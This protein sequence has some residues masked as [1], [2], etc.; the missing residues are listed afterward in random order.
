MSD[1]RSDFKYAF[2][3][4]VRQPTFTLIALLTL[5]LGIGANTAIFSVIKAVLLNPLPYPAPEQI[6]VLWEVSPERTVDQVSVPTF[7]DWRTEADTLESVAAYRHVDYSYAGGDRPRDV[8]SL[9]ATSDLFAV[10]RTEAR[11]G[12]TF[13]R[14][15]GTWGRDDVVVLSHEFWQT[16]LGGNT[17]VVGRTLILASR[18]HT[19]VGVMPRGFEF[20]TATKVELWTPLAFNPDDA[21]GR[22]RRARSLM[23][24]GRMASD[25]TLEQARQELAVVAGQIATAYPETNEGWSSRVVAA[26]EQLVASSRPALMVLMGAVGFL[27]LIVCANVANLLLARLSGRRHE[28]AIRSALG[29]RRWD[30]M[31]PVMAESLLLAVTGGVLS[32]FIAIGGMRLLTTLPEGQLLRLEDVRLDSGVLF[33]SIGLSIVVALAFGLLPALHF[34]RTPPRR[35]LSE[36]TGTTGS[37]TARRILNG[38]VVVEVAL[39]LVLLVGA[40]LM[41]RSFT[42]LLQVNPGFDPTNVVAAHVVLPQAKYPERH[43]LVRFFNDTLERLR[44][45]PGIRS[46]SA[47]SSLPMHSVGVTFALPFNVQGQPPPATFDPRADI[48]MTAPGYFETMRIRVLEGRTLDERDTTEA[49][50]TCVINETMARRFFAND[51]PIGKIIE[52]PHGRSEVVGVVADV[53]TQGLDSE[54]RPQVYLPLGQ[55]PVNG[56]A[57]VARTERDPFLSAATIEQAIWGVDP[58]QPIYDL[59]TMDQVLTRAVFLPRLTTTLLVGFAA[60]ALLLAA[61]GIYGVLSYSV[62]QRTREI[63]LR[64]ALGARAGDTLGVVVGNSMLLIG[65]GVVLGLA[66]ATVLARSMAGILYG[67]GP[68][69]LPAYGAAG[70]VLVA[71]GLMASLVPARRA[72]RVDPMVALRES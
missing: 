6:V 65:V 72:S 46:A 50:R 29:A 2:R 20:P 53:R 26:H 40:G 70:L 51:S 37:V 34:S 10:L 44:R 49:P 61:L 52:N 43:D 47:V 12:R 13:T 42:K 60:G 71:A 69:D 31:R 16:T 68:L 19:I 7:L 38:L 48:R 62:T 25:A 33:F 67:V 64:T 57:L 56:M 36:G 23:V 54:P 22:S 35:V 63:G 17:E 9:R 30:L 5:A 55:N 24:V 8:P 3:A 27:L 14:E 4:L 15:E 28:I 58:Q 11:L 39:A 1:W 18:P 41:A 32:L 45:A 66:A 59:S 21:H